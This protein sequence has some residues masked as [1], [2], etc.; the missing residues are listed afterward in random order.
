V[1]LHRLQ[2]FRPISS[3]FAEALRPPIG[4]AKRPC[5]DRFIAG[6]KPTRQEIKHLDA[7]VP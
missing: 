4:V 7:I 3:Y 2:A 6:E 5:S 1:I